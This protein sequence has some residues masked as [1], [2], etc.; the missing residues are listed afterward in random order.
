MN[1]DVNVF[2]FEPRSSNAVIMV[3]VEE[4]SW[5]SILRVSLESSHDI[6]HTSA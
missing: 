3:F 6:V 4:L 1:F 5:R 2:F